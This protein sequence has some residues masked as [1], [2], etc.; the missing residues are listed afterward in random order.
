MIL[1][2]T[3]QGQAIVETALMLAAFA[4]ATVGLYALF[5]PALAGYLRRFFVAL[6]LPFP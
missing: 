4:M 5:R 3:Q 6:A 1:K 2:K